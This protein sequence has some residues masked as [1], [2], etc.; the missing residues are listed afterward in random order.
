MLT[1]TYTL[2]ALSVEQAHIRSSLQ[3]LQKLL[4]SQFIDRPALNASQVGH[5][6]D[7]L[8]RLF[9]N[10]H[11]R[12]IELFLVPAVRR[13][14]GEAAARLLAELESLSVSAGEAVA[15]VSAQVSAAPVD[16]ASAV[17]A[18]CDAVACFC[19]TVLRRLEREEQALFPLARSVISGEAWFS[20]ANHMLVDDA[21]R[22]DGRPLR[23]PAQGSL[24]RMPKPPRRH[25]PVAS[26]AG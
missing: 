1:A 17:A 10:C 14:G 20:I 11:W 5:A 23:Q 12:K 21:L 16:S 2:V 19:D 24:P 4:Y 6:C 18:F 9:H 8:Q 7:T 25:G 15:A 26:F 13:A 22:D 3:A